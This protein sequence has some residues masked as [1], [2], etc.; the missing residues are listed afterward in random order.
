MTRAW[1]LSSGLLSSLFLSSCQLNSQSP[2][3]ISVQVYQQWE[4]QP[5]DKIA[6]YRVVGGLGDISIALNGQSVYAPFYGQTQRD[7]RQCVFFSSP[8]VPAYLFRFCGL[9]HPRLGNVSQGEPMGKAT[10][11]QF[12]TLRKQPNGTW[13][14]VEP[15][16]RILERTLKP[17]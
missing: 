10:I 4:L 15:S 5:G 17:S 11:V 16:K 2:A 1:K 3:A 6:G 8:D 7:E 9:D 12:A 14:I 13:A